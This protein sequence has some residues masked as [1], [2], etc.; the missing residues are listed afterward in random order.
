MILTSLKIKYFDWG[1][2]NT[3]MKEVI[4]YSLCKEHE[5]SNIYYEYIRKFTDE[6]IKEM[7]VKTEKIVYD[8]GMFILENNVEEIRK[9]IEYSLEILTLGVL[10]QCYINR[11]IKLKNISKMALIKLGELREYDYL[12][13]SSDFLRGILETKF[14][15]KIDSEKVECTLDN[16]KKLIDWLMATGEFKEEVKRLSNWNEFFESK[17]EKEITS[18]I[19]IAIDLANWFKKESEKKLGKYTEN[20]KKFYKLKYNKHKWKEDYIY[21]GRKEI[22]YHLN[23]VGSEILNDVY[24]EAFLKTKDKRLLLPACMRLNFDNCKSDRTKYGYVCRICTNNCKVSKYTK[25]G[26]EY[27][28]KVY[29]IPHESSAFTKE[30]IEKNY[31]GIIGVACVL[32]LISGGW[33]AIRLGLIPQCVLLDY[34]GCKNHWHESGIV[35]DINK[36]RLLYILGE[37]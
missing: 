16:F 2:K 36:D 12:K 3:I 5:N 8:F 37:K 30:K 29:I 17:S 1:V 11:A 28:F 20:V 7:N 9:N 23:M 15:T 10:W 25:L 21:C 26:N 4:T 31:V 24:R 18:I 34:C 14:L 19:N 13:K 22:E 33:K 6:V 27:G 32:N 35:T